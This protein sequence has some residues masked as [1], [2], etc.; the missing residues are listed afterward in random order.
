MTWVRKNWPKLRARAAPHRTLAPAKRI[1]DQMIMR[2]TCC[3]RISGPTS[4]AGSLPGPICNFLFF[5]ALRCEFFATVVLRT[6][7]PRKGRPARNSLACPKR[8][9]WRHLQVRIRQHDHGVFAASSSTEGIS[10]F[11][12]ASATRR[13][14]PRCRKH[15]FVRRGVDQ[16][17]ATSHRLNYRDKISRESESLKSFS[18]STPHCGVKS[19]VFADYGISAATAGIISLMESP[20]D[21]SR[22]ND[23]DD[24][25]GS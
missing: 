18:I 1:V 11:A 13:P 5:H 23:T 20:A 21:S 6:T 8:R 2:C 16:S 3:G 17:L 9:R 15:D 14:W 22:R 24:A 19:L 4:V 10:F 12:H 7:V 25:S